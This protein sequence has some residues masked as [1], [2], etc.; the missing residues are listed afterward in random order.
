MTL[1]DEKSREE[2]VRVQIRGL[3]PDGYLLAEDS[4]GERYSLSPD[5]NS[6]DFFKGLIKSKLPAAAR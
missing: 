5:G 6:L 1:K 2:D 4:Q 3:T